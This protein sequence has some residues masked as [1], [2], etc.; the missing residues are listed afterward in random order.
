MLNG[1]GEKD[2]GKEKETEKGSEEKK[3]DRD[4]D[5]EMKDVGA[6]GTAEKEKV[7]E[8]PTVGVKTEVITV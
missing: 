3:G 1:G 8:N 6:E 7:G 2:K 5:V 4:G